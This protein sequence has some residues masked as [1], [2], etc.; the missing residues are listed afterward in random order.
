MF[1]TALAFL[2]ASAI[3]TPALSQATENVE[4]A[5]A[6]PSAGLF[7][8]AAVDLEIELTRSWLELAL[9]DYES[10]KF[11]N[12]RVVLTPV[13]RRNPREIGLAVCGLVNAR[14]RMGGY[15]GFKTFYY[16]S[17]FPET[18]RGG[19]EGF[20]DT[21]C[22]RANSLNAIDYTDRLVAADAGEA[23]R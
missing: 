14:N 6:G 2:A 18:F 23:A 10:A 20:A 16:S 3:A 7:S 22:G 4:G 8:D 17:R 15:N 13:N 5:P 21:V 12:V 1:R 19:I 9:V 11:R